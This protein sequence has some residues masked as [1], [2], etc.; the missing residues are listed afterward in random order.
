MG[1]LVTWDM[2]KAESMTLLPQS[3]PASAPATPPKLQMAKAETG[4][5]KNCPL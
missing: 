5:V 3:S 4:R 1:Y 2:E